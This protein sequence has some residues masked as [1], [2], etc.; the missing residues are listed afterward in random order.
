MTT[1]HGNDHM[2]DTWLRISHRTT[3]RWSCEAWVTICC[4]RDRPDLGTEMVLALSF[5]QGRD[6]ALYP[7]RGGEGP[8]INWLPRSDLGHRRLHY[9]FKSGVG[10]H[11][12][13]LQVSVDNS[14]CVTWLR[15][16]LLPR[17]LPYVVTLSPPSSRCL[18][19]DLPCP[20]AA[21]RF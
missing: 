13:D 19:L 1:G 5:D 6:T 8:R 17:R 11:M 10:D 20:Q 18:L 16:F 12:G 9:H 21:E 3:I 4:L 2:S 15:R 7:K 14:R